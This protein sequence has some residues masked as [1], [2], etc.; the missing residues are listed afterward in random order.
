MT[1]HGGNRGTGKLPVQ[2]EDLEMN[3]VIGLDIRAGC[4][5][6]LCVYSTKRLV[7]FEIRKKTNFFDF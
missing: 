2:E 1:L 5:F 4:H 3:P 7:Q 6:R